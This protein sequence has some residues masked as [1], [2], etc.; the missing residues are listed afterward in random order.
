LKYVLTVYFLLPWAKLLSLTNGP[1]KD[2]GWKDDYYVV[3]S[4]FLLL[5]QLTDWAH[6]E[7]NADHVFT[8][9]RHISVENILGVGCPS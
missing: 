7:A 4:Y 5:L 2:E 3:S 8:M 1:K 9:N 6:P